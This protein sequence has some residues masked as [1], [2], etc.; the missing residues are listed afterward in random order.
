VTKLH[1]RRGGFTLIELMIVVAIIGILAAMAIPNFLRFELKAKSSEGKTNLAAIRTSEESYFAEYGGYVSA[2]PSPATLPIPNIKTP[3]SNA[4]G[5]G[6]GFDRVSW[7][8]EGK[9]SF[10]YS[11]NAP[12]TL[13][14]FLAAA[15]ADIDNDG[16]PQYWGY[17]KHDPAGGHVDGKSNGSFGTCLDASLT[18]ETV[19]PCTADSGNSVF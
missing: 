16:N 9:V 17:T 8:P 1:T 12:A 7:V 18:P 6:L 5:S 4:S 15:H 11:V 13:D 14:S 2:A 19:M 3:F 10:N